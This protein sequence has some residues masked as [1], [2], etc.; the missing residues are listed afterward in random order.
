MRSNQS[1][2]HN[3]ERKSA[4][5]FTALVLAGGATTALAQSKS[6]SN[7]W[8]TSQG[9]MTSSTPSTTTQHSQGPTN[10]GNGLNQ[11][12]SIP[13]PFRPPSAAQAAS[14]SFDHADTNKDGH[15]NAKEAAKLPAIG[16]RF[17]E[18]DTDQNG[19][20]SREE[21]EKGANS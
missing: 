20:L 11:S 16:Q 2:V 12:P 5:L 18:L 10:T 17:K 3:F 15:L 9:A 6:I 14:T 19:T 4:L 21:F 8:T 1:K 13:N 7:V